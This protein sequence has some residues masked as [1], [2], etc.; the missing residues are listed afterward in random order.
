MSWPKFS[1]VTPSFNQAAFLR[2]AIESVLT[3]DYNALEY[4]VIDG[5]SSDESVDIIQSYADR[6]D[7][8][9]SE[10][11]NGQS[12]ALNKGFAE[13][14]GDFLVW[15]NSD[16]VLLPNALHHVAGY[17]RKNRGATWVSSMRP[18]WIDRDGNVMRVA[19]LPGFSMTS[20]KLGLLVVGG[21]STFFSRELFR[22]SNGF[23]LDLNY[24][25]DADLWWQFYIQGAHCHLIGEPLMGFRLHESSKTSSHFFIHDKAVASQVQKRIQVES[26][27]TIGKYSPRS[28]RSW[29]LALHR[30]RQLVRGNYL[31]ARLDTRRAKGKHWSEIPCILD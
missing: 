23:N 1:I 3:Q 31:R 19:R 6:I 9:I 4:I 22:E 16:D 7:Y 12:D 28:Q 26:Q 2:E 20:A 17:L 24:T 29:A 27:Q 11:D 13:A 10:P 30:F 21:P 18:L 15:I 25:M 8:W 5:G 14:T